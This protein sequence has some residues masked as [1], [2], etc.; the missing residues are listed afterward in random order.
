M[1]KHTQVEEWRDIPGYE[2]K[3]QVSDHGRVRSLDQIITTRSGVRKR[4]KGRTLRP[5]PNRKG[6]LSVIII[7]KPKQVHRL[8][9][10]TF[11]GPAPANHECCHNDGNPANNHLTNLRWDTQSENSR[12]RIR[13]GTHNHASKTHCPRGHALAS[14]NLVLHKL[15]LGHRDCLACTRA[16]SRIYRNP[17]LKPDFQQ[18][19]DE[20]HEQILN[21]AQ[22]T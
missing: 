20:Y 18:I 9:L 10:E 11:V 2:S 3:Y 5:G 7:G 15:K 21:T 13:H 16:R 4:H 19:S 22:L 8:V 1:H 17:H 12:D 6:H 14:P